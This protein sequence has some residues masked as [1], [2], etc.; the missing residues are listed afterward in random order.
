MVSVVSF[1]TLNKKAPHLYTVGVLLGFWGS[2]L[3]PL[4]KKI[5]MVPE[6]NIK[7]INIANAISRQLK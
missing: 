7:N 3:H 2:V 4:D 6:M 5:K 1:E